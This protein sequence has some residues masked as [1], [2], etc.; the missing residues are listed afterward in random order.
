MSNIATSRSLNIRKLKTE[1]TEPANCSKFW[2]K[3]ENFFT[4]P[5]KSSAGYKTSRKIYDS[6]VNWTIVACNTAKMTI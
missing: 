6:R 4:T 2:T 3:K 5:R 1:K